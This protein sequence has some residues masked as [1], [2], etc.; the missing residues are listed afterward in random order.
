MRDTK[1]KSK[2]TLFVFDR[3]F[4]F[5]EPRLG[6]A[7]TVVILLMIVTAVTSKIFDFAFARGLIVWICPIWD[8][9]SGVRVSVNFMGYV[10]NNEKVEELKYEEK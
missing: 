10:T 9:W 2:W 7:S 6:S 3:F 8:V 5:K 1:G 4:R